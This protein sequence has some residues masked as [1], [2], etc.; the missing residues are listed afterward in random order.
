MSIDQARRDYLNDPTFRA[1]VDCMVG[2]IRDMQVTPAE[3]RTAAMLACIIVEETRTVPP[4]VWP[5]ARDHDR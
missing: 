3:A 1:V 4:L 5:L 2:W